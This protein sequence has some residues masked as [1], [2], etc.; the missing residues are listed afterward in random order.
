MNSSILELK[1]FIE[2]I[3]IK[4]IFYVGSGLLL[5]DQVKPH[6]SSLIS[7]YEKFFS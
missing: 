3:I 7:L 1:S 4:M 5:V 6:V 2:R